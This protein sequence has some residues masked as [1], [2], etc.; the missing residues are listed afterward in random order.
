MGNSHNRPASNGPIQRRLALFGAVAAICGGALRIV[1]AFIPY[2]PQSAGLETLYAA[3]DLGFLFGLAAIYWPVCEKLGWI[4]AAGYVVAMAGIAS[5]V[6]PDPRMFGLEFYM[7]GSAIFELGLLLLSI[8]MIRD[9]ILPLPAALWVVSLAFGLLAFALG[10]NPLAFIAAGST[11]GLGFVWAGYCALRHGQPTIHPLEPALAF[12]QVT[13]GCIDLAQSIA[14]YCQL[15][16]RLIVH[17][18]DNGYARFEAPN[19]ATLSLHLGHPVP[20]GAVLYFEHADLDGWVGQLSDNGVTFDQ[21]P[22]DQSWG[23]REARLRDPAGNPLCL[24]SAGVNRRF[25]PWR[26]ADRSD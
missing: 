24:F 22:I 5:I 10:G 1:A 21:P 15:G 23:W 18:P 20:A 3:I 14:F 19:D 17:S 12:N 25:P 4:G 9:K 16:F 26:V 6:G 8:A 7:V 2:V 11:L 13:I